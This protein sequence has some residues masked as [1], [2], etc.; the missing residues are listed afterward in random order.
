MNANPDCKFNSESQLNIH[1]D[2]EHDSASDMISSFFDQTKKLFQT[3]VE[4][5]Q[6]L[7][8]D[9]NTFELNQNPVDLTPSGLSDSDFERFMALSRKG[10]V[11]IYNQS[12]FVR[13][14]HWVDSVNCTIP[15]CMKPLGIVN[16]RQNCYKYLIIH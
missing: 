3:T 9:V 6:S 10:K 11:R 8:Q 5:A 4:G 1:L 12:E 14:N 7:K 13:K 2:T 16:G 15:E